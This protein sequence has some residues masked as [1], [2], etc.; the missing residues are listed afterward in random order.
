MAKVYKADESFDRG[1]L[2]GCSCA[3]GVFDGVHRGHQYLISEACRTSRES[4]GPSVV[5]TFDCDPDET[6]HPERLKKLMNNS[7]RIDALAASGVDAV[8]VLPFTHAFAAQD[9]MTFL[10]TTFDG[11]APAHLHVGN[12]FRFGARAAGTVHELQEWGDANGMVIHAHHLKSADGQPITATRIRKLLGAGKCEEARELLGHPYVFTGNVKRGRGEGADMGFK[13][14]N[15]ELP[16]MLQTLGEGVYAAYVTVDGAQYRAAMSVGVAPTFADAT[17]TCEIHILD[18]DGEIYGDVIDVEP[19][20]FLRP[21]I[22][23]D[24]VDELIATV[25][26]NIAW[27]RENL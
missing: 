26:S 15:L 3:F 14:A 22:K 17:A 4:G 7:Q 24:S 20:H 9:P 11:K 18:F 21:M 5:L 13:T 23:F 12:D 1:R 25:Q 19:L 16:A 6:F 8:V 10:Y 27:V 2:A